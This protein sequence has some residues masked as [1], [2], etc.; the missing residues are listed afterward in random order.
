MAAATREKSEKRVK[1]EV[2]ASIGWQKKTHC[3]KKGENRV[4]KKME[5]R[6]NIR[7]KKSEK[8]VK[9]KAS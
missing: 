1:N 4:A 6:R 5:K 7:G 8:R 3:H 9:D 2:R